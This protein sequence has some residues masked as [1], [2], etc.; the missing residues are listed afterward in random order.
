MT[1]NW[2]RT[3][4]IAGVALFLAGCGYT[5]LRDFEQEEWQAEWAA[6]DTLTVA[7]D[8]VISGVDYI[9]VPPP[10]GLYPGQKP[11]PESRDDPVNVQ[12]L[13]T[14]TNIGNADF[15]N[16]FTLVSENV[17]TQLYHY[18]P[19]GA[20]SVHTKGEILAPDSSMEVWFPV[21]YPYERASCTFTLLTNPIVQ[22]ELRREL[23]YRL[24]YPPI[25]PASREF[26]Y[27]NNDTTVDI[28]AYKNSIIRDVHY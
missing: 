26:R 11:L 23:W 13:V 3:V 15:T 10:V 19:I 24:H 1:P 9:V 18:S 28:P 16:P 5:I 8:L 22:R 17:R 25:P 27:D 20:L 4:C 12:L 14:V 21:E 2:H 6:I 7:P